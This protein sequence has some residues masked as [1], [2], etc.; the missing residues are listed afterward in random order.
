MGGKFEGE[1]IHVYVWLSHF[2]VHLKL[3]QHCLLAIRYVWKS[4]SPVWLF[5]TPWTSPWN[6]PEQN[7]GVGI[8]S[9]LQ[10]IFPIQGSN[11]G[12]PHCRRILYQ[13][14][15]SCGSAG[16]ESACNA[17]DLGS[18]LWSG[19]SLERETATWRRKWQPGEGNGNP[20]Q[21]SGPENSRDRG[22]GQAEVHGIARSQTRLC[23]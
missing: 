22:G 19:R 12:L 5:A 4:L 21:Y 2:A 20:L 10:K 3:S 18:I 23:D 8:L 15:S 13:L 7:T 1:S 17:G 16:K 6:S 11:W 9:L 14:Q